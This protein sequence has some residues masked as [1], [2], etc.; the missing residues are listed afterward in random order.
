ML[1]KDTRANKVK[2]IVDNNNICTPLETRV[3]WESLSDANRGR[4]SFLTWLYDRDSTEHS[5][6]LEVSSL[7]SS[8]HSL[9][10]LTF[11]D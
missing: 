6:I 2:M 3:E 10:V 9:F 5:H 4:N 1:R 8:L 11:F 7:N